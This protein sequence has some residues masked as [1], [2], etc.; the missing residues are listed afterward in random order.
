M[1]SRLVFLIAIVSTLAF[2]DDQKPSSPCK[3]YLEKCS[4]NPKVS[5]IK[6]PNK[7]RVALHSCVAKAATADTAN[8]AACT[9]T[10]AKYQKSADRINNSLATPS[11]PAAAPAAETTT[12]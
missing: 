10:M 11:N 1:V 9:T 8:G 3:V 5:A 2:A 4:N 12:Q 7:K 6:N